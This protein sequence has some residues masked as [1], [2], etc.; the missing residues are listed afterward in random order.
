M[1]RTR[2][3]LEVHE[4]ERDGVVH[5]L[6]SHPKWSDLPE[7]ELRAALR[8]RVGRLTPRELARLTHVIES[9]ILAMP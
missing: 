9:G 2:P 6:G 3:R 5:A 8:D 4:R 7:R 1:D